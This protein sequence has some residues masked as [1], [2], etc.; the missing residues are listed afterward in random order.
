LTLDEANVAILASRELAGVKGL[1]EMSPAEARRYLADLRPEPSQLP[2]M[3]QVKDYRVLVSGGSILVRILV[4]A[5]HP[6]AVIVYYHGGGWVMG[7]IEDFDLVGRQLANRSGCAVALVDYRLAPEYRFPTAVDDSYAALQWVD[8]HSEEIFG[9]RPS[10]IVAGDS[11]GGNLAAVV[12]IRAR[13]MKRPNLAAQVLLYPVTD[14][15][16][17]STS[18]LDAENDLILTR[19]AMTHFWDH[20]APDPIGRR[21]PEASPMSVPNPSGLPPAVVVT[22]EHDVLRDDGELYATR[23]IKA[24]VP[25]HHR[26]F[27]G[28]MHGFFTMVGILPASDAAIEFVVDSLRDFGAIGS[29]RD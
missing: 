12:S 20:Y 11:A 7:A 10:L 28:Q 9:Y 6:D 24:G 5:G 16:F 17:N 22:A 13:E 14:C 1:D 26:R 18:Y 29:E 19:T 3:A 4:P 2:E 27:E 25:V 21:N 23:L 15:D 8:T